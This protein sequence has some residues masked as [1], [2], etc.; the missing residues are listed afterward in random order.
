M[1]VVLPVIGYLSLVTLI[2]ASPRI[3]PRRTRRQAT[4]VAEALCGTY[5]FVAAPGVDHVLRVTTA[6]P[7][8][9]GSD[10][11]FEDVVTGE[12]GGLPVTSATYVCRYNGSPH[13]YGVA[14][15]TMPGPGVPERIEIRSEPVFESAWAIDAPP[16]GRARTGRPDIDAAF[17]LYLPDRGEKAD[18]LL[19]EDSVS[20]LLHVSERPSLRVEGRQLLVWRRDGWSSPDALIQAVTAATGLADRMRLVG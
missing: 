4:A 11:R 13:L 3:G 18:G 16:K 8:H 1:E 2:V 10:H 9:Y 15:V 17:E 5:G 6:P 12:I 20:A 7:F 14:A 19:T